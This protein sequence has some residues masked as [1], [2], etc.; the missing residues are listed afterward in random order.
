MTQYEVLRLALLTLESCEQS[1]YGRGWM[2]P[3]SAHT[4]AMR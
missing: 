4:T 2:W 1:D 3:E